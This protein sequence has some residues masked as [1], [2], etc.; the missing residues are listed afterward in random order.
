MASTVS[1]NTF[2]MAPRSSC[3]QR[4]NIHM[5]LALPSAAIQL[6]SNPT[7]TSL[8]M[9]PSSCPRATKDYDMLIRLSMPILL[10]KPLTAAL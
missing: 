3:S 8:R 2:V 7:G 9:R 1:F 4:S 10:D 5:P 6:K